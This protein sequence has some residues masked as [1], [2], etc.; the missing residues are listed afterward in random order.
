MNNIGDGAGPNVPFN[1]LRTV[2]TVQ[3]VVDFVFPPNMLS[4]PVSS[5]QRAILAPTN[6]QI[7]VYND[8]I[9][10]QLPGAS[11]T[12]I[13]ADCLKEVDDAGLIPPTSQLDYVARNT[14]PGLPRH[15]LVIKVGG[16]YRLMR[17][18]SIDRGLVKNVRVVV[19]A[20]GHRILTVR[21]VRPRMNL[22]L[23]TVSAD[24]ILLPRITFDTALHSGHTLRRR[25]IPLAPAYAVTF[26]GCQGLTLDRIAVDV[27]YPVFSHGQLYTALSRVR[28]RDHLIIRKRPEDEY[29]LSVTYQ[30]ILN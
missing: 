2:E 20:V 8:I 25:Q 11:R 13:A 19:M 21:V 14:P 29:M 18:L 23:T 4:A 22:N 30:E 5:S 10:D 9:I 16:V 6:A 27:S 1:G 24:D 7:D 12:Y 17:N 15:T 26:N 28:R 3:D